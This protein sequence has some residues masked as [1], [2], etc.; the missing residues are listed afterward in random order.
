[1]ISDDNPTVR[2]WSAGNALAWDEPTA[3]AEL[4]RL[5]AQPHGLGGF[6][7]EITLREFDAGRLNTTWQ[8]KAGHS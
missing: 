1:L 3:R 7:A 2:Q 6:E 5:A 8:P 4:E